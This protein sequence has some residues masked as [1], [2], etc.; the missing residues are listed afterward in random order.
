MQQMNTQ[1]VD[2]K[3]PARVTG[4]RSAPASRVRA[5]RSGFTLFELLTV[6]AILAI[7]LGLT[8][9]VLGRAR[10]TARLVNNQS[11]MRDV[12]VASQQFRLDN[13][14]ASP[15]YFPA[16]ELGSTENLS[17]GFSPM[18]SML[19]NLLGGIAPSNS[20]DPDVIQDVGPT[21]ANTVRIN[22]KAMVRG[23][24]TVKPGRGAYLSVPGNNL[25][26]FDPTDADEYPNSSVSGNEKYDVGNLGAGAWA[27]NSRVPELIDDFGNPILAWI[28]DTRISADDKVS[29]F[30]VQN[31]GPGNPTKARFYWDSNAMYL[32]GPAYSNSII[33]PTRVA[34]PGGGTRAYNV[35]DQ[36][37]SLGGLLGNPS[38][39][40]RVETLASA[41]SGG[42]ERLPSFAR[43]SIVLHS[44]GPDGVYMAGADRGGRGGVAPFG[45]RVAGNASGTSKPDV[46]GDFDDLVV[47][48]G[49]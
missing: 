37:L 23:E 26:T 48:I 40:A 8:I 49:N 17:R 45:G 30:S 25:K 6:L 47:P 4:G 21:A 42:T 16:W 18:Q 3:R 43:A 31:Y 44:A 46:M 14:D 36:A 2:P 1:S 12:G 15:S 22:A 35:N 5:G 41:T 28:E 29:P 20:S 27:N 7:L 13:A 32:R 11:L 9:P 10:K 39:A 34:D 33:S 38:F 24:S 19:L